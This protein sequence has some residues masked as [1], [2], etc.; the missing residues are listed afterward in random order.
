VGHN[1]RSPYIRKVAKDALKGVVPNTPPVPI[2]AL[3]AGVGL[4]ITESARLPNGSGYYDPGGWA[5]RL[6]R[7]LFVEAPLN[8]NRRRFTLA[9]EL[10]HCLLEHGDTSCWNLGFAG[11]AADIDDLD[12]LPD[13]EQEAHE[14]ARELLLPR[15]WLA[16]DWQEEENPEGWASRYGVS[17]DTFFIVL[18]ERRLLMPRRKRR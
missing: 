4:A 14:F 9:H 18:Q 8:L 2:D 11:E 13:F 17:R 5:I 1:S 10:G 15:L 16:R 3:V 12:D 6:S 7:D